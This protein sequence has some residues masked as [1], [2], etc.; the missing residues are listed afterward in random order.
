MLAMD[1][2]SVEI[3]FGRKLERVPIPST[4]SSLNCVSPSAV[5][6]TEDE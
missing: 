5:R 6:V 4:V 1:P 2:K 3:K